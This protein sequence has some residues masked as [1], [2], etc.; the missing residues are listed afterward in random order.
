MRSTS[1]DM[2]AEPIE[3]DWFQFT[4]D[5][6]F[7]PADFLRHRRFLQPA[8][9]Q[10]PRPPRDPSLRQLHRRIPRSIVS[11]AK[12]PQQVIEHVAFPPVF[13]PDRGCERL[14]SILVDQAVA[15]P[16]LS[17]AVFTNR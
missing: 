8:V 7:A 11:P 13:E 15:K 2:L 6:P 17:D 14:D 9:R 16:G 1:E 10:Q 4:E 12:P 5:F 3:S